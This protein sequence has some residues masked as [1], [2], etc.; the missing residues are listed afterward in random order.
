VAVGLAHPERVSPQ[1]L[2]HA[3]ATH[4]HSGGTDLRVLQE[5]PGHAGTETTQIHTHLGTSGLH[6]MVRDVHPLNA[7]AGSA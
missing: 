6:Q 3:F 4:M 7:Q 1:V 2:R 5:L